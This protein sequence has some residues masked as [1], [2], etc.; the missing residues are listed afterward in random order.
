MK[1]INRIDLN[2]LGTFE[3]IYTHRGVTAAARHLN[4]SQSA[5][6]HALARLRAVFDDELF[7]RA[8]NEI[9]PTA[10]ARSIIDPVRDALRGLEQALVAATRFDPATATRA[11]RIGLRQANE[12]R[13]FA[14][15]VDR[16]MR[17]APGVTLASVDFRRS[18]VAG[19]LARGDLDLAIDVASDATAG[20]CAIPVQRDTMVVAARRGHPGI[21][22]QL[23]LEAYLAADHVLASPR[24]SG[25]GLEDEAL[26]A[27][28]RTRRVAVRCQNIWSAWRIVAQSD[29]LLTLL[30]THADALLPV[31]DNCIVPLPFA[32]A[33]RPLQ[34][35]WHPVAERDPGNGWLR[36][37]ILDRFMADRRDMVMNM[38]HGH[39]GEPPLARSSAAR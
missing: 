39:D 3:A 18:D 32:I 6:S 23:D 4:L 31:A 21:A 19:A 15:I 12:A 26:A 34:L 29:M 5:I 25:P 38:V 24:S 27:M 11:F 13:V 16:A 35:L 20:L 10:L 36:A 22:A 33:P 1:A 28:G 17:A 37:L 9:V 2:L 8:G 7:V 30:G 14:G